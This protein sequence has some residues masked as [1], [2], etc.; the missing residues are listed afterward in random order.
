MK[1]EQEDIEIIDLEEFAAQNMPIPK[2][3][4]Y[5]FKVDNEVVVTKN[6]SMTAEEILKVAGK[7]QKQ[8]YLL[9]KLKEKSFEILCF[10]EEVD[11]VNE[12]GIEKFMTEPINNRVIV[13]ILTTQGKW[14]VVEPK[15]TTIGA[16]IQQIIQHFGFAPN[17]HYE[18]RLKSDPNRALDA[19]LTLEKVGVEDCGILIF[20]DLG[21][22]A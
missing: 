2:G 20:T 1:N 14:K 3:K 18:L 12:L 4:N 15:I 21:M 10:K 8:L 9:K 5:R 22:A 19:A 16:L 13:I 11:F 17:G 6:Q 7:D